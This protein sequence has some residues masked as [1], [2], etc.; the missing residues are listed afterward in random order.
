MTFR[1]SNVKLPVQ[2]ASEGGQVVRGQIWEKA[3]GHHL[4]SRQWVYCWPVEAAEES[5]NIIILIL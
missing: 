2:P 4:Q 3:E 5:R 1:S